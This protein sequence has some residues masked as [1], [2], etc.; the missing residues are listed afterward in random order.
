MYYLSPIY[1]ML[2][3]I[4]RKIGIHLEGF[5]YYRKNRIMFFQAKILL[6]KVSKFVKSFDKA[7][8]DNCAFMSK[9]L[10]QFL[11]SIFSNQFKFSFESHPYDTRWWILGYLKILFYHT[12][13]YGRHSI[14]ANVVYVWN[15]LQKSDHQNVIFLQLRAQ[16]LKEIL[17]TFS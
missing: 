10:K 8:L 9:S 17:T 12:K 13:T 11:P 1:A 6:F 15:H 3:L 4:G 2:H 5:I 14:F 7:A 16:K